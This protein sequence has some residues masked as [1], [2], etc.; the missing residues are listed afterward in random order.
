MGR[1]QGMTRDQARQLCLPFGKYRGE[2][3]EDVFSEDEQYIDWLYDKLNDNDRLK[4]AIDIL[5]YT[6]DD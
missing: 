6:K 5:C 4:Q 1:S 3:I 2:F